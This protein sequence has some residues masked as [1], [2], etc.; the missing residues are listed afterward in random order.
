MTF[1]AVSAL[2]IRVWRYAFRQGG[3]SKPFSPR[4]PICHSAHLAG[5]WYFDDS[6]EKASRLDLRSLPH[7]MRLVDAADAGVGQVCA[8]AVLGSP[9]SLPIPLRH[10]G[11]CSRCS[12]WR[13]SFP[14]RARTIAKVGVRQ[15]GGVKLIPFVSSIFVSFVGRN[16]HII[17]PSPRK[18]PRRLRQQRS[19]KICE[20][21]SGMFH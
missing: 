2:R 18:K 5:D 19:H 1:S 7:S 14:I 17:P 9:A 10:A 16:P 3:S 15:T 12:R 6:D 11:H 4:S 13:E 21:L 20:S 8:P